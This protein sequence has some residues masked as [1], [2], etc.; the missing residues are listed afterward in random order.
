L[1]INDYSFF[2]FG[3]WLG[4]G[5]FFQNKKKIILIKYKSKSNQIQK[6]DHNQRINSKKTKKKEEGRKMK[7]KKEG[8]LRWFG[9]KKN[10]WAETPS[11]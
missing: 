5:H 3:R 9:G 8:G 7:K 4:V 10:A 6:N 11:G 1:Y 2:T